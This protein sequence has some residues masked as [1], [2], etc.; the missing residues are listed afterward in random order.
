[1][2]RKAL[3]KL[4]AS[5]SY[6]RG[7][8]C[9]NAVVKRSVKQSYLS[10]M[11]ENIQSFVNVRIVDDEDDMTISLFINGKKRNMKRSK[12]EPL[13]KVLK[14]IAIS[15]AEQ[16][17]E[18]KKKRKTHVVCENNTEVKI[19][20]GGDTVPEETL[21]CF[22][23]LEANKLNIGDLQ[24]SIVLNPPSVVSVNISPC[25]MVGYPIIP[26]CQLEFADHC[27]WEWYFDKKKLSD[28]RVFT[29][30]G[31]H[32]GHSLIVLCIPVG[33]NGV[34]GTTIE[35]VTPTIVNGPNYCLSDS[36]YQFTPVIQDKNKLRLLSYNIL[37]DYYASQQYSREVLYPYCKPEALEVGYRQCLLGKELPN[38]HADILCLQEVGSHCYT[39]Y[40]A[41]LMETHGYGSCFQ[42]KLGQVR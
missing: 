34:H 19:T 20:C 41:P 25:C 39:N 37:A 7:V 3:K 30:L 11:A 21:N 16:K 26:V 9:N 35:K 22:A 4:A 12:E 32:V 17:S 33:K 36:R 28:E 38:Y 10:I 8:W 24:Y 14:R 13:K 6:T 31:T 15:Q 40:L 42:T 27:N 1:M 29:P 5:C 18:G 23:W 2:L